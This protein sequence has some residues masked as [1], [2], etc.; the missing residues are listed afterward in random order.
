MSS[1]CKEHKTGTLIS[2][3]SGPASPRNIELVICTMS[4]LKS[5]RSQLTSSSTSRCWF[6]VSPLA[7]DS[8]I[9]PS[10]VASIAPPSPETQFNSF[11]RSSN[12]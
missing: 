5:S 1:P 9:S 2:R 11:G 7:T 6:P 8:V 3:L 4:G 10:L 12:Q